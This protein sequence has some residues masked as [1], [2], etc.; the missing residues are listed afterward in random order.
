MQ[1]TDLSI[2]AA[3]MKVA[4]RLASVGD[5]QSFSGQVAIGPDPEVLPAL[6]VRRGV[7]VTCTP[8][9]ETVKDVDADGLVRATVHRE[10]LA[11]VGFPVLVDASLVVAARDPEGLLRDLL[12]STERLQRL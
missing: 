8:M 12:R 9:T 6:A 1:W 4:H 5:L 11:V 7:G 10:Q 3:G 2:A